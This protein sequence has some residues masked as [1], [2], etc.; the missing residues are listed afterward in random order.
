MKACD[1]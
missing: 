1:L